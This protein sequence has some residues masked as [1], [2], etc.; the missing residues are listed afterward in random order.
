MPAFCYILRDSS[1]AGYR[2]YRPVK[3]HTNDLKD[4][5]LTPPIDTPDDLTPDDV[6]PAGYDGPPEDPPEDPPE[7]PPGEGGVVRLRAVISR[8]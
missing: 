4:G 5:L 2:L 8:L 3:R 6:A 7:G 1:F